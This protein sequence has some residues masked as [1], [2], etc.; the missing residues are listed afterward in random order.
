MTQK[1]YSVSPLIPACPKSGATAPAFR[2]ADQ[3]DTGALSATEEV[4]LSTV[5]PIGA[6]SFP[7]SFCLRAAVR[8]FLTHVLQRASSLGLCHLC[9]CREAA[10]LLS[11]LACHLSFFAPFA[12]P[13]CTLHSQNPHGTALFRSVPRNQIFPFRVFGVFRGSTFSFPCRY[14][15]PA[16]PDHVSFPFLIFFVSLC[17]LWEAHSRAHFTRMVPHYFAPYRETKFFC[18]PQN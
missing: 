13:F 1:L 6:F 9:P 7:P 14:V 17:A 10:R 5:Y 8:E 3:G 2:P 4:C 18:K 16:R 12:S 11:V 15:A